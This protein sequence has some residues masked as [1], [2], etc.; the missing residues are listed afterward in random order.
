M[1]GAMVM[2]RGRSTMGIKV[3]PVVLQRDSRGSVFEPLD[4]ERLAGQRNVH[5]VVTDPGR[6]RGNHYHT[7]GT[8][9]ITVEGPVLVRI[10][11]EQGVQDTLIP[12]GVVSR[13][14]IPPGVAHA[15]QNL[16]T[17]PTLLV[18]FRDLADDPTNPDV[19]REV[20]IE[21]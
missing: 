17:R 20:L 8:E 4:A 1:Q 9:M 21:A 16:G 6:V 18:A 11:D 19:V 2:E 15:I 10:R 5:V 7:R 12:E 13:F 3:E 14:I